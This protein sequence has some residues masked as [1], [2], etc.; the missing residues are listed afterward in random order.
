[1]PEKQAEL[2]DTLDRML[3]ISKFPASGL[4]EELKSVWQE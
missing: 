4:V 1:M 3:D 2:L